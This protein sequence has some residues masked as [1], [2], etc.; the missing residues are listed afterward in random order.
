MISK[1]LIPAKNGTRKIPCAA[2]YRDG[3]DLTTRENILIFSLHGIGECANDT[4]T[5]NWMDYLLAGGAVTLFNHAQ[6]TYK[7]KNFILIVPQ[8]SK[9]D[10]YNGPDNRNW[11]WPSWYITTVVEWAMK[12]FPNDPQRM[13]LTGLSLGGGGL[14]NFVTENKAFASMFSC[15]I[16]CCGVNGGLSGMKNIVDAGLPIIFYHAKDDTTV[17]SW[18][19]ES[20]FNAIMALGPAVK[21]FLKLI[22]YGGHGIWPK[23]YNMDDPDVLAPGVN[24]YDAVIANKFLQ[25][26]VVPDSPG[27]DSVKPA[28]PSPE[29]AKMSALPVAD[30]GGNISIP[31]A[32]DVVILKPGPT[33]KGVQFWWDQLDVAGSPSKAWAGPADWKTGVWQMNGL[34]PGQY[35]FQLTAS[36]SY[37]QIDKETIKVSVGPV[38]LPEIPAPTVKAYFIQ[39]GFSDGSIGQTKTYPAEK[40]KILP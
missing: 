27:V 7:G 12:K 31:S 15:V 13:A 16:S 9:F 23:L 38:K 29:P 25:P 32:I 36:N 3:L 34:K 19:S 2:I 4:D 22:D 6:R 18:D 20:A 35:T 17:P 1:F 28:P 30:G 24:F 8:L 14:L 21:P 26:V 11:T 39:E 40:V 5:L 33:A 10:R 37:S